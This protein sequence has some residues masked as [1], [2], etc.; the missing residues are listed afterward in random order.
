MAKTLDVYFHEK[1][2]GQLVQDNHGDMN[3]TY[4]SHWLA[5]PDAISISCSLPLQKET[6]KRK[7]CQAFFGG[8]L[9]EENQRKLIA[10]NL[11]ISAT[12]DFSMLEKIG[13]ECAGA[14]SFIP[15]GEKLN[16]KDN[17]YH[18]LTTVSLPNMLRELPSRPLLAGEQGV[19][20]SL[21]GV[22]DKLAVY[23]KGE[24]IFIPLNNAPSTHILK[25]DFNSYD[26]VI[27]N[28]AFCLQLAKTIGLKVVEAEIKIA[29]DI[30]YLLIKRY[31]RIF[32]NS[33][34]NT[35]EIKRVHQE[36]FCQALGI[37]SINK[38]QNEGGPSLKQCF[39]FLRIQS[40]IPVIDLG[41]LIDAVIFNYLI[42]NCDAHGKNFSLLY[43]DQIQL[44]PLYDLI[45]TIYYKD[46]SQ[47]MA[48]KLG[49]EYQINNISIVNFY[50]LANEISFSK[51]ELRKRILELIDAIVVSL[52]TIERFHPVQEAVAALIKTRCEYFSKYVRVY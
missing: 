5:D 49:G 29:E 11:G 30:N 22:Q 28:E 6:F 35:N 50:K 20:L 21:A 34:K 2:V 27:F 4:L 32:I 40:A 51:P 38:Y 7:N 41:K 12:N 14:L 42:G 10:K 13:G 9:P 8:I 44:A 33:E 52:P 46:L 24:K 25:P 43:L 3:F 18:E 19:R 31:D 36:D 47:K 48:M 1:M 26:G 17:H 15:A 16:P 39:D 23:V 37:S 45:S